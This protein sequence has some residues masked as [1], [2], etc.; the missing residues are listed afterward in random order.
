MSYTHTIRIRYAE[1]DQQGVAFHGHWLA[2][3]DD[4]CTHFFASLG[5]DAKELFTSPSGFDMMVVGAELSWHGPA[6]FDDVVAIEVATAR[7]GTSSFALRYHAT[8]EGQPVCDG[9]VTYVS[10][11]HGEKRSRPIPD[12]VRAA[13]ST[14]LIPADV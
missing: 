2:F 14:A 3:F 13:L 5:F 9:T 12:E 11:A 1:C 6:G 10:I 4:A 7:I 8:V